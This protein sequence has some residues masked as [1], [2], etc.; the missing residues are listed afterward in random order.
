MSRAVAMTGRRAAVPGNEVV[1]LKRKVEKEMR[2]IESRPNC[3]RLKNPSRNLLEAK[4][5]NAP[6]AISHARVGRM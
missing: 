2:T 5:I 1:S 4:R 6:D 3:G